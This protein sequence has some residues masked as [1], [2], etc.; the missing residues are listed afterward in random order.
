MKRLVIDLPDPVK[1]VEAHKEKL[2]KEFDEKVII[3]FNSFFEGYEIGEDKY[4]C[5]ELTQECMEP[6]KGE[7]AWGQVYSPFFDP[8]VKQP[9]VYVNFY[10]NGCAKI[11]FY[12]INSE[13]NGTWEEILQEMLKVVKG[14]LEQLEDKTK[15]DKL[16]MMLKKLKD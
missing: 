3:P 7:I 11:N 15:M 13:K 14:H 4:Q 16:S 6:W 5:C 9:I 10:F 8:A 2:I 12:E 1:D